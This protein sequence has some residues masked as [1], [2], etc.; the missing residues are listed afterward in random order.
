MRPAIQ[1]VEL[2]SR[3]Y[4]VTVRFC[5]AEPDVGLRAGYEVDRIDPYPASGAE[6]EQVLLELAEGSS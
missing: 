3:I 2:G 5:P 1:T 6:W 4:R